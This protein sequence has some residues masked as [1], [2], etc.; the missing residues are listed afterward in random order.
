MMKSFQKYADPV[1]EA[2]SLASAPEN[3]EDI[4][5]YDKY[6]MND[7]QIIKENRNAKVKMLLNKLTADN[8]G[9]DLANF[10][11]PPKPM[12]NSKRDSTAPSDLM[13]KTP[14][15]AV[16]SGRSPRNTSDYAPHGNNLG[17]YHD[18]RRNYEGGERGWISPS[19]AAAAAAAS[20][21]SQSDNQLME[22]INYMIHLLEEQRN[23]K[24]SN[25][26]E[27]FI[28]YV[29]LGVFVIFVVDRF[30]RAGKYTR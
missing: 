18:Y 5:R 15:S 22:K 13:P 7:D 10:N 24:T 23:E 17:V 12:M 16:I 4:S 20:A 19:A 26:T 28:L 6:N 29:F 14:S 11:P 1:G 2:S 21:V 27:E 8:D 3:I 30:S 9:K 25:V